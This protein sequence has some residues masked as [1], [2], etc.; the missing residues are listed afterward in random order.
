MEAGIIGL[1][2]GEDGAVGSGQSGEYQ[3]TER[4]SATAG[5]KGSNGRMRRSKGG[6]V[7]VDACSKPAAQSRSKT[8]CTSGKKTK[9]NNYPSYSIHLQCVNSCYRREIRK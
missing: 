7:S 8:A 5:G 2:H 4:R 3:H 1:P 9:Q 6:S